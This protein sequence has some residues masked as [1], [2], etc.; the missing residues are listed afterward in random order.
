M[1]ETT[2]RTPAYEAEELGLTPDEKAAASHAIRVA[3]QPTASQII[4]AIK[5]DG[6]DPALLDAALGLTL[7]DY[8]RVEAVYKAQPVVRKMRAPK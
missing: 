3:G 7:E 2:E 8:R 6:R 5:R 1:T 4:A